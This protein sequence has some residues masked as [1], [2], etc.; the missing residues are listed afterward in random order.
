MSQNQIPNLSFKHDPYLVCRTN[1]HELTIKNVIRSCRTD[2]SMYENIKHIEIFEND[3]DVCIASVKSCGI[4]IEHMPTNIQQMKNIQEYAIKQSIR[5]P[6]YCSNALF[7]YP[8]LF[9]NAIPKIKSDANFIYILF[10]HLLKKRNEALKKQTPDKM[11]DARYLT[12]K[13]Y[14]KGKRKKEYKKTLKDKIITDSI[15]NNILIN[16]NNELKEN[17]VF[18]LSLIDIYPKTIIYASERIKNTKELFMNVFNRC[19]CDNIFINRG[20]N[21]KNDQDIINMSINKRIYIAVK[22]LNVDNPYKNDYELFHKITSI[23][24]YDINR[25]NTLYYQY[26]SNEL[27]SNSELM[28]LFIKNGCASCKKSE[29]YDVFTSILPNHFLNNHKFMNDAYLIILEH[30][31]TTK[32]QWYSSSN[33]YVKFLQGGSTIHDKEIVKLAIKLDYGGTEFLQPDLLSCIDVIETAIMY[34]Y[35]GLKYAS[36]EIKN[37]KKIVNLALTLDN[38][39]APYIGKQLLKDKKYISEAIKIHVSIYDFIPIEMQLDCNF[40]LYIL[41]NGKFIDNIGYKT[42]NF[43]LNTSTICDNIVTL[44]NKEFINDN[45]IYTNNFFRK[46]KFIINIFDFINFNLK[47][48]KKNNFCFKEFFQI[49]CSRLT[50]NLFKNKSI[51]LK[52]IEF[53]DE[54]Y[55]RWHVFYTMN[56]ELKNDMD[57]MYYLSKKYN[58]DFPFH[59]LV[60]QYGEKIKELEKI[61]TNIEK[62]KKITITC[63]CSICLNTMGNNTQEQIE[64]LYLTD[65]AHLFH[66]DCLNTWKK[67][68]KIKTCPL[69]KQLL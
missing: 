13:N 29:F 69:C 61:K 9:A 49:L 68:C 62:I 65:C 44:A 56:E 53:Y 5:S 14:G 48:Q 67:K 46:R 34:G 12:H 41:N 38:E 17:D 31:K 50:N 4:M 43:Q 45:D 33:S 8:E 52:I 27:K 47:S 36:D 7:N 39:S 15:F 1:P 23:N 57:F 28:L 59:G 2:G 19:P 21:L 54:H 60:R 6:I 24:N 18:M 16:L 58:D 22:Y 37:N 64:K 55:I 35:E 3:I 20:T 30:Q 40:I 63:E 25:C 42:Y 51:I 11:C 66:I 32:Y 26:A 10:D